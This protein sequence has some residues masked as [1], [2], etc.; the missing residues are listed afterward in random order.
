MKTCVICDS[1]IY[2]KGN[3]S[4]PYTK[5]GICC[6]KCFRDKILPLRIKKKTVTDSVEDLRAL[7]DSEK[8]AIELYTLA[9]NNA[10]E[11]IEREIYM[12]ILKDEKD[13]LQK[14]NDL[15][16]GYEKAIKVQ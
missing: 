10:N 14:L 1:K 3:S 11:G 6:D 4:F 16:E 7:I 2:G 9:I 8:E 13:H 12:E 5:S 15:L